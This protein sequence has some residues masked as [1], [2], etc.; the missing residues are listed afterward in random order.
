MKNADMLKRAGLVAGAAIGVAAGSVAAVCAVRAAKMKPAAPIGAALPDE[1]YRAGDD[2]VDRFRTLLRIPTVSSEDP[3]R[4]NREAFE[5]W[6]PTLRALYPRTFAACELTTFDE[7]GM[8]L[9]WPGADPA[10]DPIVMMAHHDVVPV[11]GQDWEHDP[12]GAQ[13]IDGEIW[14]RGSLDTKCILAA[15]FECA[16]Q[17]IAEGFVPP[18]DVYF[19]SSNGEEIA[20][21]AASQA[22]AW[23]RERGI[24]PYMVLDEGGAV[25][26]DAP[27]GV[28]VPVAMVGVSEKGH[29]DL[30]VTATAAGGH[31]S[32]PAAADATRL[33][34]RT[35]ERIAGNPGRP[36]FTRALDATL[37]ELASRSSIVNRLVFSNLWLTRPLVS[38]IMASNSETGAM[39]RTT[40]A[41]T[42]LEGSPAHNVLPTVARAN[43]NVRIAPFE[44][45]ETAIDRARKLAAQ[46]ARESGVDS[47]C[48]C[49]SVNASVPYTE[50]APVSPFEGDP[51]FDYLHRCVSS[52]YPEAGFAPYVQNSC[53]DSREFNAI[54]ERVYRFCGFI[55]SAQA[56]ALIHTANERIGVD[57][58]KR[59]VEFYMA[60]LRNLDKLA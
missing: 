21:P 26:T 31:A 22:V 30:T 3:R 52:V 60:F 35:C 37:C 41:L 13:I 47:S 57:V 12:F 8:L 59:G 4:V 53:T 44:D 39:L 18:R 25:A 9:R 51:A 56:R 1:A 46:E 24:H 16:E 49:V 45:V 14:A 10:L 54:C 17:L 11:E 2:A 58:Y 19:F 33:L 55:Y 32:T 34:V 36:R 15:F 42:Q 5:R 43:F 50:P 23:M 27:L 20:G 6:L 40:Y 29:V 28:S 38:K 48:V 7:F